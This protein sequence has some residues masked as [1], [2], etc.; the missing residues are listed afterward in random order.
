M[1]AFTVL[2]LIKIAEL[3]STVRNTVREVRSELNAI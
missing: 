3:P 1:V 2:S